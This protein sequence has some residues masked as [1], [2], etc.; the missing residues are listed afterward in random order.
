MTTQ[1]TIK[2]LAD[3]LTADELDLVASCIYADYGN[4]YLDINT[5]LGYVDFDELQGVIDKGVFV[6]DDEDEVVCH[7]DPE[8]TDAVRWYESAVYAFYAEA[9]DPS[10]GEYS[11]RHFIGMNR[12]TTEANALHC[13]GHCRYEIGKW[14]ETMEEAEAFIAF[15]SAHVPSDDYDRL[16]SDPVAR[17]EIRKAYF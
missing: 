1:T 13:F 2:N 17:E 6:L 12:R 7:V 4:G 9:E 8:W 3:L 16:W 10:N 15:E 14:F 5:D 11:P